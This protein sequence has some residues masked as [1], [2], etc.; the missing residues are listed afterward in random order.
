L[1]GAA[2]MFHLL[3]VSVASS[4]AQGTLNNILEVSERKNTLHDVTG[5]LVF[6]SGTFIQLIEGVR[7]DVRAL[8]K[9]ILRDRRHFNVREVLAFE[10]R[11]RMFPD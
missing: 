9:N 5:L 3:Y 6:R 7:A 1:A 4:N 11:E 10:S 8:Y 2:L